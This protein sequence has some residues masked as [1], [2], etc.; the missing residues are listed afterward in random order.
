MEIAQDCATL[1][2]V[3]ISGNTPDT[4]AELGETRIELVLDNREVFHVQNG[5]A[6]LIF[7]D[8]QLWCGVGG[9]PFVLYQPL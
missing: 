1:R 3:G 4:F 5:I 9:G 2:A 7:F 6:E 8:R